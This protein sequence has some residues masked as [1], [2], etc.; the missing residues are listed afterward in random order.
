MTDQRMPFNVQR[1]EAEAERFGKDA[2][3]YV[4]KNMPMAAYAH[5]RIAASCAYK[6]HPEL[7]E[8]GK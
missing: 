4:V 8:P 5:A 7:R 2:W 6:A 3:G 1:M